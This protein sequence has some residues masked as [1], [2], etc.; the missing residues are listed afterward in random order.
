MAGGLDIEELAVPVTGGSLAAYRF[1]GA[2]T[3]PGRSPTVVAVHGITATS[4]AWLPVARA[5]GTRAGLLA[6]DLRG[7]GAS[8]DLPPPY[9]VAVHVAD[10]IAALEYLRLERAVLVGHSLGAYIVARL[11]AEHPERVAAAI[12]VDGGLT[13]PGSQDVDPQEFADAFLGPALARLRMTFADRDA[14][15]DWWRA[16]PALAGGQIDDKDLIAYA[17]HDLRGSEPEL[18][19]AANEEAVR[20]DAGELA[21]LGTPAHRLTVPATLLCAPRGL[22]NEPNPMQPLALGQAWAAEAPERRQAVLV[23]DVNH[24]TITLA[25]AGAGV[26]AETVVASLERS[27][28]TG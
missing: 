15:R 19:P 14:Y 10:I 2:A 9:G 26:V 20:A 8:T 28:I 12:L 13:I 11:A 18:R 27:A 4:R 24:Y 7:R 5:L 17:D 22:L 16:H 21:E 23:P 3:S 1:G 25:A 6:I